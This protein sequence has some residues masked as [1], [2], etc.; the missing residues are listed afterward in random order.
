MMA[1]GAGDL[2]IVGEP[3]IKEESS[4]KLNEF[5]SKRVVGGEVWEGEVSRHCEAIGGAYDLGRGGFGRGLRSGRFS[6]ASE[7]ESA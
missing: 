4:S 7:G 2:A 3:S 6:D 1:G 5:V